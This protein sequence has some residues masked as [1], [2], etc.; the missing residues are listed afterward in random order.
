MARSD[1]G[2]ATVNGPN[3]QGIVIAAGPSASRLCGTARPARSR[4]R[5]MRAEAFTL[6]R[7]IEGASQLVPG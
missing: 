2:W 7:P 5:G 3:A 6:G 1:A 4:D